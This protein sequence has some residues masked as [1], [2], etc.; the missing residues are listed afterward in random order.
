V[1]GAFDRNDLCCGV[2][3]MNQKNAKMQKCK[4]AKMQKCKIKKNL[5]NEKIKACVGESSTEALF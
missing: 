4:N 5:S 1:G 2:I 3:P